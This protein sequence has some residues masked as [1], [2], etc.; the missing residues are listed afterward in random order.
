MGKRVLFGNIGDYSNSNTYYGLSPWM[1]NSMEE[2]IM[3]S[4]I[5][6]LREE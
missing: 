5:S 4:M 3:D 2:F 6:G 1:E